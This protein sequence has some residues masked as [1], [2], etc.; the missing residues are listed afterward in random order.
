MI[1]SRRFEKP[2]REVTELIPGQVRH[3]GVVGTGF[4]TNKDMDDRLDPY[5]V[6]GVTGRSNRNYDPI[7]ITG[8]ENEF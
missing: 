5:N 6:I 4:S 1:T 2:V 3:K 8:K 7:P